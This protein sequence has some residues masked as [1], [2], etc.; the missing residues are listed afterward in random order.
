MKHCLDGLKTYILGPPL[1]LYYCNIEH[2]K[3]LDVN[4]LQK[5]CICLTLTFFMASNR[6]L[7]VSIVTRLVVGRTEVEGLSFRIHT[8]RLTPTILLFNCYP[9]SF[10]GT[11]RL[12]REVDCS[13]SHNENLRMNTIN[14]FTRYWTSRLGKG[15]PL[16]L[17]LFLR[18]VVVFRDCDSDFKIALAAFSKCIDWVVCRVSSCIDGQVRIGIDI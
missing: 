2:L 7:S 11:Q 12:G 18:C 16:P 4:L 1:L 15:Q 10:S 13:P 17:L 8:E 6:D 5:L 9:S 3:S 14:G